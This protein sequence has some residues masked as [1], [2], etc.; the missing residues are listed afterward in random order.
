MREM[1]DQ[2]IKQKNEWAEV[3]KRESLDLWE[4][5]VG[6][7]GFQAR[8]IAAKRRKRAI[9]AADAVDGTRSFSE[10]TRREGGDQATEEEGSGVQLVVGDT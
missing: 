4:S 3:R 5:K 10:G 2:R 1:E 7:R 9:G 6:D 8:H